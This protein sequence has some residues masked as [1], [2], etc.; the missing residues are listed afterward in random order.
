[1]LSTNSGLEATGVC[2]E[3]AVPTVAEV[4]HAARAITAEEKAATCAKEIGWSFFM[5]YLEEDVSVRVRRKY[6]VIT[7]MSPLLRRHCR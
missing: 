5:S 4:A 7:W 3:V 1:M 6:T 2:A